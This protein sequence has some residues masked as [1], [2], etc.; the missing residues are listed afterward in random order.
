M[1]Q[2]VWQD[3]T[4]EGAHSLWPL[5]ALARGCEPDGTRGSRRLNPES[6]CYAAS[7]RRRVDDGEWCS[8]SVLSD[9]DHPP[10]GSDL[11]LSSGVVSVSALRPSTDSISMCHAFP[12]SI[13]SVGFKTVVVT[14]CVVGA[15]VAR[16]SHCIVCS[17]S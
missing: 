1:L 3:P 17:K 8:S 15:F 12:L 9:G 11:V 5:Q 6:T 13:A 14:S 7:G 16:H 4:F 10:W 2:F